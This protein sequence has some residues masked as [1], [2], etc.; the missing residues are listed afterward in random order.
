MYE[1]A[2]VEDALALIASAFSTASQPSEL[3]SMVKCME[4]LIDS[5]KNQW[6]LS[7]L[8]TVADY[9]IDNAELS[10]NSPEH[11]IRWLNL[12]GFCIRPG[13]G[14]AFDEDRIRKLWKIYLKGCCFPKG[15]QNAVEWW[16]FCR[17]IAGGLTAGQQRLFFQDVSACLPANSSS[18]KKK[19]SLQ[20]MTEIW[21]ALANME[22]LLVKDKIFLARKLLPV[23][24][25]GKVP[26]QLFWVLSRLGA[27]ELLYG[28]VDRVVSA[29]EVENWIKKLQKIKWTSTNH[30]VPVIL[31]VSRIMRKTGDRTRD[32]TQDMIDLVLPWL[33]KLNAP[34]ESLS[35]VKEIVP[36]ASFEESAIFGESLPQGLIL[37]C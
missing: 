28:S 4:Q 21:M 7:F 2:L 24:K 9:L 34:K 16:I 11:E 26:R 32:V 35:M 3:T 10:K 15:K 8:R 22:R 12:T 37:K 27:R 19:T 30:K 36:I 29:K 18:A 6:P 23:L 1:D 31:A 5:K 20:E 25:P 13:F 17:R 14:D 33:D